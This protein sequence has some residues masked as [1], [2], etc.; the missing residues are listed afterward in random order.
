MAK[1]FFKITFGNLFGHKPSS[2]SIPDPTVGYQGVYKL[3]ERYILVK[4]KDSNLVLKQFWDNKELVFEQVEPLKFICT[5]R[6][7]FSL[8]FTK[9]SNGVISQVLAFNRDVWDKVKDPKSAAK[10]N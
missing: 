1:N 3:K 6:K 10:L 2:P 8:K 9:D 4:I 7:K 5:E